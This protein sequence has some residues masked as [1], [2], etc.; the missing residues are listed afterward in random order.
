MMMVVFVDSVSEVRAAKCC[1]YKLTF[2]LI[3]KH[4]LRI[5]VW[6]DIRECFVYIN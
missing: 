5:R 2:I 4:A 6:V 1:S 3:V